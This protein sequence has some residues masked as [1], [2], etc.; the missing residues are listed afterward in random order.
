MKCIKVAFFVLFLVTFS[1]AKENSQVI[2]KKPNENV[3][4]NIQNM[5]ISDYIKL[6]AKII[7][8]N[9][10]LEGK[11]NGN[12]DFI[13]TVPVK[14]REVMDILLNVLATKGY[15]I[16][17]D[18]DFLRV[19]RL[20]DAVKNALPIV[21]TDKE[22]S[23]KYQMVTKIIPIKNQNV[24]VVAVKIRHLIS[25]GAKLVTF[26]EK[27]LIIL[28]DFPKNIET[29]K[30]VI[31]ELQKDTQKSVVS[32]KLKNLSVATANSYALKIASTLFNQ[33][34]V[35]NK[36][37]II[38]MKETKSITIIGL[39]NNIKKL[40]SLIESMDQDATPI[41][42]SMRVIPLYNNDV[43]VLFKSIVD[44]VKSKKYEDQRMRPALSM[45]LGTNSIVAI[46]PKSELDTVERLIKIMDREKMQVYVMARIIEISKTK[47]AQL[48][49]KYG[50]QAGKASNNVGLFT[51]ASNFGGPSIAL[52][53]ALASMIS[54]P[55]LK[56]G[57]ALGSA[58][59]FLQTHGAADIIS[60]PSILC[61]DNKESTIFVGQTQSILTSTSNARTTTDLP[62]S[63]FKREKIG[64]KLSVKPRVANE[65]KVTL[66]I[67]ASIEDVLGSTGANTGTPTTLDREVKTVTI[68]QNGETVILG[69]LIK[70]KESKNVSKIPLL[71]YIPILGELFTHRTTDYD[72]VNL[73][74]TLT[75]YIIPS[76]SSL[77]QLREKLTELQ[78]LRS[79]YYEKAVERLKKHAQD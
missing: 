45:D 39:K 41:E 73:V 1:V 35:E 77:S 16:V 49:A 74:I 37:T 7:K 55:V 38:P 24:D 48:G 29:I 23:E 75:P 27:N 44:I 6:T 3:N 71:G 19:I 76:S 22:L 43:K 21:T 70:K 47:A 68:V 4:I 51:I 63:T 64:I 17:E 52:D 59:D 26:K 15:T 28:S 30:K 66:E 46:G 10:L 2:I 79:E 20:N 42:Q 62:V 65:K 33:K 12:I 18:G 34:I 13:S 57:L 78:K 69:G 54:T 14:K 58:I 32:I 61:I 31:D 72:N 50:L 11:I 56:E 67:T 53:G 40:K 36:L 8:K 60:E 25:K 9:I 5:K